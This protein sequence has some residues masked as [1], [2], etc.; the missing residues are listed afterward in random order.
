MLVIFQNPV[1]EGKGNVEEMSNVC[2]LVM[3]GGGGGD[4]MM[5]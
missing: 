1:L 4:K 3:R 2:F 5:L